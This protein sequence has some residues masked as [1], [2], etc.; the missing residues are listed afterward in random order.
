MIPGPASRR[1][2]F[3]FEDDCG[4]ETGFECF[5]CLWC[6]YVLVSWYGWAL[7]SDLVPL[8]QEPG[9]RNVHSHFPTTEAHLMRR[10][11]YDSYLPTCRVLCLD[12]CLVPPLFS[13]IFFNIWDGLK[14]LLSTNLDSEIVKNHISYRFDKVPFPDNLQY[15]VVHSYLCIS[16]PLGPADL[17]CIVI[18]ASASYFLSDLWSMATVS[19]FRERLLWWLLVHAAVGLSSCSLPANGGREIMHSHRFYISH[20]L[21]VILLRGLSG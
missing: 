16:F 4:P 19:T 3:L 7:T 10:I 6:D 9:L 2:K 8:S 13:D 21:R 15:F 11:V 1:G 14:S 18:C 12:Q 5:F 20:L 17:W